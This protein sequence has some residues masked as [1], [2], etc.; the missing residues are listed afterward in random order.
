M[1]RPSEQ[2]ARLKSWAE[3]M[4]PGQDKDDLLALFALAD[5]QH[6]KIKCFGHAVGGVKRMI[7]AQEEGFAYLDS[8]R[9]RWEPML[10]KA[11]EMDVVPL[12]RVK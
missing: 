5:E 11:K 1:T 4:G 12:K 10:Q 6:R 8:L 3:A 9:V 2:Y 7:K